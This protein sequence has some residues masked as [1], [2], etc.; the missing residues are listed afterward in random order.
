MKQEASAYVQMLLEAG[1]EAIF[2]A[3]TQRDAII[4]KL[5]HKLG[6][7]EL[8][9]HSVNDAPDLRKPFGIKVDIHPDNPE[10]IKVTIKSAEEYVAANK[11][12]MN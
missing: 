9:L 4:A 2:D 6:K 8:D 5:M 7:S 11:A 1:P 3:I 10:M 12:K